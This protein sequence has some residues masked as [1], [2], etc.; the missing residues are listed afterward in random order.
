MISRTGRLFHKYDVCIIGGGP[1]G[2]AAAMRA[3]DYHK[4]VCLIEKQKIG[5]AGLLDGALSSKT[6]WEIS[7]EYQKIQK[8]NSGWKIGGKVSLDFPQVQARVETACVTKQ[9]HM[10]RQLEQLKIDTIYGNAVFSSPNTVR[11]NNS[12]IEARNF[13]IATGSVPRHDPRIQ[14]DGSVI[15]TSDD[16]GKLTELPKSL[17]IVGAG[18]IGS[19]FA[20]IFSRFGTKV[21]LIDRSSRILPFEDSDITDRISNQ[22]E[23]N[24]VIIHHNS[25]L[26]SMKN[27]NGKVVY[28]I[29]EGSERK[30]IQVEKALL[31]IGREPNVNN[32]NLENIGVKL[33]NRAIWV[34]NSVVTSVPHIYAV[35]DVTADISLAHIGESEARFAIDAMFLPSHRS[36]ESIYQNVSKIMFLDPEVAAVG[37]NEIDCI[38]QKIPYQVASFDYELVPRAIAMNETEGFVKLLVT[39]DDDMQVLGMRALGPHASSLVEIVSRLVAL[40][41]PIQDLS[42]FSNPAYPAITE[43]LQE[44]SRIFTR[45][46]IHKPTVF[47]NLIKWKKVNF[48]GDKPIICEEY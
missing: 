24:G 48:I 30:K 10:L 27:M 9:K 1:A 13:V 3:V 12:E 2:Y 21:Y 46:S 33:E 39:N 41:R 19:E 44:C 40:E 17:V 29:Q 15:M 35:G 22:F 36:K 11:V 16:I 6:M 45:N 43:G 31:S 20:T 8:P 14:I 18:V 34:T 4:S 5:G 32:L 7:N 47:N 23:K 42:R 37:L 26:L 38:K 25:Q 28:E